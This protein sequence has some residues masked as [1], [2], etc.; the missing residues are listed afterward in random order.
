MASPCRRHIGSIRHSGPF[1][2]LPCICGES[3]YNMQYALIIKQIH[4][5]CRFGPLMNGRAGGN[6]P[7]GLF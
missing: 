4:F 1:P 2:A 5:Q 7:G 3:W 6:A